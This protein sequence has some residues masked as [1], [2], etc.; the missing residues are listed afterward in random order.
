MKD[1]IT[2]TIPDKKMQRRGF[3]KGLWRFLGVVLT[4]E[5]IFVF[6]S[7]L[8]KPA[9]VTEDSITSQVLLGSVEDFPV[10]SV[11]PDRRN[12]LYII[13]NEEGGFLVLSLMCSHLGC[14]VSWDEQ[15]NRFM[16]PC[17]SSSFDKNG[18]VLNSPAPRPLDYF[19][20]HVESGKLMID[21]AEKTKRKHFEKEQVT[22][23]I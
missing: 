15:N 21:P 10:N 8:R 23:I 9:K 19:P 14:S 13:R 22:Y 6:F 4:G 12:K 16:C 7:M 20:V 17:H 11:T 18:M 2:K 5:L 3:F 1:T